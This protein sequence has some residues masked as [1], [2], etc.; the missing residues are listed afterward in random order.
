MMAKN[1]LIVYCDR[2]QGPAYGAISVSRNDQYRGP[3]LSVNFG[4]T[5]TGKFH[6]MRNIQYTTP[7]T[8]Y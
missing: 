7:P 6:A 1:R 3:P 8:G 2:L 4:D 5:S